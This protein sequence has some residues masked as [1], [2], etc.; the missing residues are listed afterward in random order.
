MTV[1]QDDMKTGLA[2]SPTFLAHD[3][4][5]GHPERPARLLAIVERLQ[6]SGLWDQLDVWEPALADEQTLELIH[7]RRHIEA[8]RALAHRGGYV[9]Q[10]T[11]VSRTSWEPALRAVSAVVEAVELVQRGALDNAYC[12]PRPPGHHATPDAAMGFCLFNNVAI[13][14]AWLLRNGIDRV[15]ILDY[16]VHHGNGTQ[17]AFLD[18]PRVLYVSTH[19]YPLYPGTGHWRD[20][21]NG[22]TVNLSVPPGS[23][24]EVYTAVLERIVEP[25]VRRFQPEL[26][27]V[28]LGFDAFWNDPLASLRLSVAGYTK[29]IRSARELAGGRLVIAL[30]GG[31]DLRALAYG[32]DAVCRLLLGAEPLEDPIGPA[33]D[34]LAL[35]EVEPLLKA[36]AELHQVA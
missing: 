14:A 17:D 29:L 9:D 21:G 28:S 16:D 36:M 23:G 20:R 35:S 11:A 26:I 15:A 8:I 7:T 24:D 5:A 31:Y 18:E 33:P 30:E 22:S 19:Q 10:D 27:V 6:G 34:Q 12:L 2:Y 25:V 13:A 32:S 4:G 3:T 1:D